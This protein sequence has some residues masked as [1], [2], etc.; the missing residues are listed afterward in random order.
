MASIYEDNKIPK[1]SAWT[2]KHHQ[3][4]NLNEEYNNSTNEI[5]TENK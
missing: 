1:L 5:L 4:T 2:P 3:L